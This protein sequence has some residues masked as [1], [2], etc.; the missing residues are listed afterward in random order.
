MLYNITAQLEIQKGQEPEF[1][2]FFFEADSLMDLEERMSRYC[3]KDYKLVQISP[4]V[5]QKVVLKSDQD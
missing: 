5:N 1:M 2:E 3:T 4:I